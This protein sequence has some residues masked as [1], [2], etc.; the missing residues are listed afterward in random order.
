[1]SYC[2]CQH[3]DECFCI[4][5]G[6]PLVRYYGGDQNKPSCGRDDCEQKM[7]GKEN[8]ENCSER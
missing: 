7:I 2:Y 1:M 6:L 4:V 8:N 3:D 5:C